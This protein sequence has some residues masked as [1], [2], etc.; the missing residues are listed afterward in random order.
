MCVSPTI[1]QSTAYHEVFSNAKRGTARD[2]SDMGRSPTWGV[3]T[4]V[5]LPPPMDIPFQRLGTSEK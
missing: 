1:V 2:R 5:A 4:T 3:L